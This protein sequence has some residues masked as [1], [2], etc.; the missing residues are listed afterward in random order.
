MEFR[1]RLR[2]KTCTLSNVRD[3]Y[4][5]LGKT[6]ICQQILVTISKPNYVKNRFSG[7]PVVTREEADGQTCAFPQLCTAN[8]TQVCHRS[9]RLRGPTQSYR[10]A[11]WSRNLA[12]QSRRRSRKGKEKG[13]HSTECYTQFCRRK[14]VLCKTQPFIANHSFLFLQRY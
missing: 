5:T 9:V 12:R 1:S 6:G 11:G 13:W 2:R 7:S 14:D 8:A 10:V 3:F 4:P